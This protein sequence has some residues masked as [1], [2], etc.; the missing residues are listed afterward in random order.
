MHKTKTPLNICAHL[1][2]F[3]WSEGTWTEATFKWLTSCFH[4]SPLSVPASEL[5]NA[6]L[7]NPGQFKTFCYGTKKKRGISLWSFKAKYSMWGIIDTSKCKNKDGEYIRVQFHLPSPFQ[8]GAS[9]LFRQRRRRGAEVKRI[10]E[11]TAVKCISCFSCYIIL[12]NVFHTV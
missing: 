7:R 9:S 1:G 11:F 6:R 8:F 4:S 3:I 2:G 12:I 5:S 10:L